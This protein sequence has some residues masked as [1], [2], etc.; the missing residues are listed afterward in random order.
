MDGI[1]RLMTGNALKAVQFLEL[2]AGQNNEFPFSADLEVQLKEN[3]RN[4]LEELITALFENLSMSSFK[5][6]F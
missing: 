4:A 1:I 2:R 5:D 6:N 3:D